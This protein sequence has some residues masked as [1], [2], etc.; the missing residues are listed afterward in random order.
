MSQT[1]TP[2]HPS[3][4]EHLLSSRRYLADRKRR[5]TTSAESPPRRNAPSQRPDNSS[6]MSASTGTASQQQQQPEFSHRPPIPGSSV[7]TPID[8]TGETNERP[9]RTSSFAASHNPH[10]IPEVGTS[11]QILSPAGTHFRTPGPRGQ[12]FRGQQGDVLLPRWQAD[13][14]VSH[15]PVCRNQFSFFYRKHHCRQVKVDHC[16]NSL[17]TCRCTGSVGV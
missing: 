15:C 16:H 14:E 12:E 10:R 2:P 6:D 5:L 11:P 7:S 17:L 9:T 13:N 3:S 4:G 1:T 8:L